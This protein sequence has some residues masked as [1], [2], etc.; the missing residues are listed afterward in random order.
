MKN[1]LT[2]VGKRYRCA[3]LDKSRYTMNTLT[4]VKGNQVYSLDYLIKRNSSLQMNGQL[5]KIDYQETFEKTK[6]TKE[7]LLEKLEDL[8]YTEKLRF[9]IPTSER[10]SEM[11]KRGVLELFQIDEYTEWLEST[12]DEL[13]ALKVNTTLDDGLQSLRDEYAELKGEKPHHLWKEDR[14]KEEIEKLKA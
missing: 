12:I 10:Y 1:S 6:V 8:L 14:L 5:I 3:K 9:K 11:L 4:P 2:V 13:K 7:V